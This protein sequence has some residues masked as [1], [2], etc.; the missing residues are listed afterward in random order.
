MSEQIVKHHSPQSNSEQEI[1]TIAEVISDPSVTFRLKR[2]I[3]E[4]IDADPIDA[5]QDAI[6]LAKLLKHR[7][8][9]NPGK[10]S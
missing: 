9:D 5:Y 1:P 10:W 4:A 6:L 8:T 2:W 7:L 3:Q